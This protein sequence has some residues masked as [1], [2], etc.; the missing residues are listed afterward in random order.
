MSIICSCGG[1][2]Q[3][4]ETRTRENVTRRRYRCACGRKAVSVETLEGNFSPEYLRG[5]ADGEARVMSAFKAFACTLE[6]EPKER[7]VPA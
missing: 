4:T 3:C 1:R 5:L 6:A 7:W 2:M